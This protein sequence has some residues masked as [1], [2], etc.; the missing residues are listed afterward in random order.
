PTTAWVYLN[1]VNPSSRVFDFGSGSPSGNTGSYMFLSP[2]GGTSARFAITL[3]GYGSEQN[4]VGNGPLP[5][6]TWTHVAVVLNGSTGTFYVNGVQVGQNTSMTLNPSSL[7]ATTQNYIG[8]SQFGADAYLN[9]RVDDFRIYSRPLS[10][11]EITTLASA[12]IPAA[13]TG[14]NATAD[15]QKI[16]L[17]WNASN[18]AASYIVKRATTSGG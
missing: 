14:L 13:P 12:S 6:G 8:K 9:G 3:N 17:N 4:I 1:S 11:S 5:T 10:P 15:D 16:T 2:Q 18:G 7:G